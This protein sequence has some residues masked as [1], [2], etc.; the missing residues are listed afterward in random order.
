MHSISCIHILGTKTQPN[1][2]PVD[3]LVTSDANATANWRGED[4]VDSRNKFSSILHYDS[5]IFV[6]IWAT[7]FDDDDGDGDDDENAGDEKLHFDKGMKRTNGADAYI[8]TNYLNNHEILVSL[9]FSLQQQHKHYFY[10]NFQETS[11]LLSLISIV[12]HGSKPKGMC[13]NKS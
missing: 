5:N 3:C 7:K 4:T 13:N 12:T 6:G 8:E 9:A 1:P 2:T 11:K 10:W